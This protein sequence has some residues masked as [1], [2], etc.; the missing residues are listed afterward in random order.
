MGNQPI[1]ASK[2]YCFAAGATQGNIAYTRN[3]SGNLLFR[4][5]KVISAKHIFLFKPKNREHFF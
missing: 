2:Q 1:T 3:V 5:I 4:N